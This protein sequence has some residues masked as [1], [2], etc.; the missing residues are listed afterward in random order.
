M[1]PPCRARCEI[2]GPPDHNGEMREVGECHERAP[3][4]ARFSEGSGQTLFRRYTVESV[5]NLPVTNDK[6][7]GN[8]LEVESASNHVLIRVNLADHGLSLEI[9]SQFFD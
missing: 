3:L 6:N 9:S 5:S 2:S 1:E 7:R 4:R 8:L